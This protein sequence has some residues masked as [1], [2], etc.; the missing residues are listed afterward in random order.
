MT[1]ENSIQDIPLFKNNLIQNFYIIG[2]SLED[3]FKI[4]KKENKGIFTN[5]FEKDP[6][7]F[8][9]IITKFP[10]IKNNINNIPDQIIIDH[11][12]PNGIIELSK[13]YHNETFL[14]EFDNSFQKYQNEDNK[15]Y[16]KIYFTC[17]KIKEPL[18]DY[19]NYMKE[20]VNITIQNKFIEI[21]E[22]DKSQSMESNEDKNF[23]NLYI[24][25]I[26]CFSSV[27]PFYKE[28]NF[29]LQ[30]IFD[31]YKSKKDFSALP[32]EKIIEKIM[33]SLPLPIKLGEE[34][35]VYFNT[36]NFKQKMVFPL[37]NI[38]E[39]NINYSADISLAKIFHY[40]STDE[41]I[42]IFRYIL[43]E[44]PVLFFCNDK[45]IL[46][47]FV[48]IFLTLLSP[49]KYILPHISILPKKLY[50]LISAEKKFVFGINEIYNE[51]FF[52]DNKIELNKTLVIISIDT[53]NNTQG[54]IEEKIYDTNNIEKIYITTNILTKDLD[55]LI[56][57]NGNIVSILTIDIPNNFKKKLSEDINKYISFMKKKTFFSK[58]ETEPKDL[59]FKIQ[60]VFY[61]FF[62][63]IMK[64][65]SEFLI[66]SKYL[67]SD[68][69]KK[70]SSKGENVFI[71]SNDKFKKEVFLEDEFIATGQKD[72]IA[73]YKIFFNT[74]MFTYFLRERIYN[75]EL[76]NQFAFMQFDQ[77]TFLKKNK[78]LKKKKENKTFYE[79][80]KKDFVDKIKCETKN[81][82]IINEGET[83]DKTDIENI[84]NN[85]EKNMEMIINY[86]QIFK[87][88]E[89]NN[90]TSD[91]NNIEIKYLIFPK[92]N[93]DYL[94]KNKFQKMNIIK[95]NN[96]NDFIIACKQKKEEYEKIRPYVFYT[97]YFP[98]MKNSNISGVNYEIY[99]QN[100]IYYIWF[101]LLS[102]SLW[103]CEKEEKNFR[104]D[105]MFYILENY[106]IME[107]YVL[108][109]LFI[110]IYK[111]AEAFN[112][113]KLFMIYKKII[114]HL[115]YFFLTLF[116]DKIQNNTDYIQN[117]S[118][119]IDNYTN[120]NP[121]QKK[122]ISFSKRFL[123]NPNYNL[124]EDKKEDINDNN[125]DLEEIIFCSE[126]ICP[127]CGNIIDIDIKDTI[128]Y[129]IDLKIN[130]HK[131]QCQ[132]CKENN[133]II[134][135]YQIL[136]FNYNPKESFFIE[137]G[138]FNFFTPFKLYQDIKLFFNKENDTIL[139]INNI[140]SLGNKINLFNIL[141]YFSL[142][143][144]PFDFLFPYE[145]ILKEKNI[146]VENNNMKKPI[147]INIKSN[148][149]YFRRFNK[150]EP[151]LN[152]EKIIKK[153]LLGFIKKTEYINTDLSFSIK[154]SKNKTKKKK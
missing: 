103:Y 57:I 118:E 106:K 77:L 115:D 144:L 85:K 20:I 110:N 35:S 31:Y 147:K 88:K 3:F 53:T 127:K 130:C 73:F 119:N 129:H 19:L 12:F 79:D 145:K 6:K 42:R 30:F 55:E 58:K 125:V 138:Q 49:F 96:L 10:S 122:D 116:C 29:L 78:D 150:I 9:K 111:Y 5:I 101:I 54:K 121:L 18:S 146:K 120:N 47:L 2:F 136:K 104:L 141:F 33:T 74:E 75:T 149:M 86:G 1:S 46:S 82:I 44:I 51:N 114:G 34:L 90:N 126:Q 102:A 70:N 135:K 134:I 4:D 50:G 65:Y 95:N 154:G 84:L 99:S 93:F 28:L 39:T 80:F 56:N 113:V 83:F 27:L 15:F 153:K 107:K 66:E 32:L 71:K 91:R 68:E 64:G 94:Y 24:P 89:D 48:N 13:D 11:C 43:Y 8:P 148:K 38:H 72:Y 98:K 7:I 92:L 140:L 143:N 21:S 45:L 60:N 151:L 59:T 63:E 123:I 16:S 26:I 124:I 133:D 22:T 132:L 117:E 52:E 61:K 41:F 87:I 62:V 112:L 131:Y 81:E 100:Y 97:H 69:S 142:L 23:I 152:P 37:I 139:D 109:F 67:Y 105:K 17:L 76:I 36:T 25:K 128:N 14:L 40:F 137:K 108:D